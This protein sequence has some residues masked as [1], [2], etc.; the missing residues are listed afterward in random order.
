MAK[1]SLH[2]LINSTVEELPP[3]ESFLLDYT[4]CIEQFNFETRRTPTKTYKPSSMNCVRNMYFQVSGEKTD[5][6]IAGYA[7]IGMGESGTDRHTRAQFYLSIMDRYVTDFVYHD[8]IEYVKEKG[9][10][11]LTPFHREMEEDETK[12]HDEELNI[13]FQCDGIITY[14]GLDYIFEYKTEVS[15]K[16]MSRMSYADEHVTQGASYS[17]S[18][19]IPRVMF[20]YENRD[21][22]HKKC[23]ILNVTDEIIKDR[24]LSKIEESN[25]Y[26]KKG[27]PP[28][29]PKE[30]GS[31]FCQYCEYKQACKKVS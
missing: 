12:F 27:F 16:E 9:L 10:T 5:G 4:R 31:K 11:H 24:V 30:A 7:S 19:R 8:P 15:S 6:K 29:K 25:K 17:N 20:L 23:F 28:P 14:K 13:N 2:S 21:I 22:L 1:N 3:N 18:F 26:L